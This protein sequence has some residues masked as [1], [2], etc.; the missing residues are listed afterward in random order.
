MSEN[1][2]KMLREVD[3]PPVCNA[4]E[5]ARGKRGFADFTRGTRCCARHP[6]KR[7]SSATR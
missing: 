5:V 1:L 6:A 7:P 4:I 3:T 2:F